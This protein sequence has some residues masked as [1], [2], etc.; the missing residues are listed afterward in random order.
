M[1]PELDGPPGRAAADDAL[2]ARDDVRGLDAHAQHERRLGR[3]R[4]RGDLGPGFRR[5]PD[6]TDRIVLV[7]RRNA[8]DADQLVAAA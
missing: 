2:P 1:L 5:R 8:E 3:A 4:D 7:E 6:G